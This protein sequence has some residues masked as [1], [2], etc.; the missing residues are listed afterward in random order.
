MY[1]RMIM[2]TSA[3]RHRFEVSEHDCCRA[4]SRLRDVLHA[5]E[6]PLVDS[7]GE[8]CENR[9]PSSGFPHCRLCGSARS[10]C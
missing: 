4:P 6:V 3:V 10:P 2:R 1:T 5:L 9:H 7:D 8:R